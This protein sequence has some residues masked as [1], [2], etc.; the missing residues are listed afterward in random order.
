[1][2]LFVACALHVRWRLKNATP[3]TTEPAAESAA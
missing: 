2:V 3:K 1:V